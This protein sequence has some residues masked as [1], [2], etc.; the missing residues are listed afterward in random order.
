[1]AIMKPD[2]RLIPVIDGRPIKQGVVAWTY[3]ARIDDICRLDVELIAPND[4]VPS[5]DC[6]PYIAILGVTSWPKRFRDAVR[7]AL[8]EADRLDE[9]REHLRRGAE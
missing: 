5:W 2:D 6:E 9:G 4:W 8:D 3:R 1:M 7:R